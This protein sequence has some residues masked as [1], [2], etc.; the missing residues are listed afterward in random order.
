MHR[1]WKEVCRCHSFNKKKIIGF[2]GNGAN[3]VMFQVFK[4]K[5]ILTGPI[6]NYYLVWQLNN[7]KNPGAV[8]MYSCLALQHW[9]DL[10]CWGEWREVSGKAGSETW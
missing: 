10:W 8:S 1:D 5:S 7:S 3:L 4:N 2:Y 9:S 6:E